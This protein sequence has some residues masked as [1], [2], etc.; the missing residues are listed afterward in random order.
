MEDIGR[1][2]DLQVE[3]DLDFQRR[4]W[5]IQRVG[6][7]VMLLVVVAALLGLFGQGVLGTATIGDSGDPLQLAYDRFDRKHAPTELQVEVAGRTVQEGQVRLWLNDRFLSQIE[8]EQVVPE[9]EQVLVEPGRKVYVFQAG[10][11][12]SQAVHV[13]FQFQHAAF[14]LRSGQIGLVNGDTLNFRQVV[15][16]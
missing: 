2:G 1:V 7:V 10:G 9:P 8:L 3:Q 16:P 14:G 13:A 11:D 4:E 12:P 5:A 15:Y 6:W